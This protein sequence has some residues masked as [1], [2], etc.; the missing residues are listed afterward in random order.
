VFFS[1]VDSDDVSDDPQYASIISMTYKTRVKLIVNGV[2][3]DK[4]IGKEVHQYTVTPSPG[5][6]GREVITR[7]PLGV[8]SVVRV[9]KVLLCNTC[10]LDFG[11]RIKMQVEI[12]SEDSFNNHNVYLGA[13]FGDVK[14]LIEQDGV[15]TMNPE[16][17]KK[18]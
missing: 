5:I 15:A 16:H 6:G 2:N 4:T 13:S 11:P 14:F 17:F 12:L 1:F 9:N 7:R 8:G 10:Y 3:M 18:I